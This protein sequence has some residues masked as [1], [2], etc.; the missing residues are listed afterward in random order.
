M[1]KLFI[2]YIGVIRNFD[3]WLEE[4]ELPEI[5]STAEAASMGMYMRS[6]VTGGLEIPVVEL[7][8][9]SRSLMALATSSHD[10]EERL[11][12]VDL[13]AIR[14]EFE[15]VNLNT[16]HWING[17]KLLADSITKDNRATA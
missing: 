7:T 2:P 14:K 5:F 8:I 4:A 6:V 16:V 17:E 13:T 12:M 9:Y 15:T 11:N 1:A 10:P 3:E